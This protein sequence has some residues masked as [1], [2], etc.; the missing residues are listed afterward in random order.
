MNLLNYLSIIILFFGFLPGWKTPNPPSCT[1]IKV[2]MKI[3]SEAQSP[4]GTSKI[5]LNFESANYADFK[6]FLFSGNHSDNRLGLVAPEIKSLSKGHY[7]LIIQSTVD[8]KFCPKEFK[9]KIN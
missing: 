2:E 6:L 4:L 9:F 3:E 5:V 8:K 1:E 7:T